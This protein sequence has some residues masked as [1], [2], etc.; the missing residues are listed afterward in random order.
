MSDSQL[1]DHLHPLGKNSDGRLEP[2]AFFEYG[3]IDGFERDEP[4]QMI[5]FSDAA[6]CWS[7]L[8][9]WIVAGRKSSLAMA[10]ARAHSL[11]HFLDSD[12]CRFKSLQAIADEAGCTRAAL[13]KQLLE[14]RDQ[15]HMGF[16]FK[17]VGSSDNYRAGQLRALEQGKHSSQR[18]EQAAQANAGEVIA[19]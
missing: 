18:K 2:I 10:G 15:L 17:K 8:L 13:S 5:S 7:L 16:D 6:A 4:E 1:G 3:Q 9:E 19:E 12:N 14:L 11:L